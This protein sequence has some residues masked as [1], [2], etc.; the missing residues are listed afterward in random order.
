MSLHNVLCISYDKYKLVMNILWTR[1]KSVWIDPYFFS[2]FCILSKLLCI[3][4]VL[5][6]IMIFWIM[7]F[8]GIMDNYGRIMVKL[9]ALST[10]IDDYEVFFKK[11]HNQDII[12]P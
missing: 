6:M 3:S 8:I 1:S 12:E 11:T 2:W 4:Y 7:Y 9:W 10:I 5:V